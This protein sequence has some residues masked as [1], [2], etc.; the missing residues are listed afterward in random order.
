[1]TKILLSAGCLL[2][3]LDSRFVIWKSEF[4]SCLMA[5][6]KRTLSYSLDLHFS[7]SQNRPERGAIIGLKKVQKIKKIRRKV[8]NG[9]SLIISHQLSTQLSYNLEGIVLKR[10]SSY[11]V[12]IRL[13]SLKSPSRLGCQ[14]KW[15]VVRMTNADIVAV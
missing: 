10:L 11:R 3:G 12:I 2:S 13:I 1:M 8:D 9:L 7:V 14:C 5:D 15:G 6:D 4:E